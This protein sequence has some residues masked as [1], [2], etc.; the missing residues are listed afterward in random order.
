MPRFADSGSMSIRSR[1]PRFADGGPV[2]AAAD[3]GSG[4][5]HLG[6]VDL[7]TNHGPVR[8]AVDSNGISQLRKAAV[9]KNVGSSAKSSWVK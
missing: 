7:T 9:Y 4:M 5:P 2:Y 3:S 8:V 1:P 6:T